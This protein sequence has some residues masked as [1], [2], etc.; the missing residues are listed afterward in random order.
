MAVQRNWYNFRDYDCFKNDEM[1]LFKNGDLSWIIPKEV[2]AMSS[3]VDSKFTRNEDKC[4][5][6]RIEN[7]LNNLKELQIG[8]VLRLNEPLY[9]KN[10][11]L[12]SG[13][14]HIDLFFEDG[15]TP[16]SQILKLFFEIVKTVKF[17]IAVHCKA[18]L[19][20]TGTLICIYMNSKYSIEMEIAVAW[21]KICRP[22]S[23]TQ[24]QYNFLIELGKTNYI[25]KFDQTFQLKPSN[26]GMTGNQQMDFKKEERRVSQKDIS[27]ARSKTVD[28]YEFKSQQKSPNNDP[29]I[30]CTS[31][32][33]IT[34]QQKFPS[35]IFPDLNRL[36]L[37]NSS[38]FQAFEKKQIAEEPKNQNTFAQLSEEK[39]IFH[40][41]LYNN[42]IFSTPVQK[43]NYSTQ[44]RIASPVF[45][46]SPQVYI[47]R[48]IEVASENQTTWK[49]PNS[50]IHYTGSPA[51]GQIQNMKQ[52]LNAKLSSENLENFRSVQNLR[53]ERKK[54]QSHFEF[55]IETA[56]N[57]LFFENKKSP[58]EKQQNFARSSIFVN[59]SRM[60]SSHMF[61]L[62]KENPDL[63]KNMD[64]RPKSPHQNSV[65]NNE[66]PSP[67]SSQKIHN[68]SHDLYQKTMPTSEM[69]D[70]FKSKSH[71]KFKVNIEPKMDFMIP[72]FTNQLSDNFKIKNQQSNQLSK[73]HVQTKNIISSNLFANIPETRYFIQPKNLQSL[74]KTE[75]SKAEF[76]NNGYRTEYSSKVKY[77]PEEKVRDKFFD[78]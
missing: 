9:D 8:T 22:G 48:T 68:V 23:V 61:D 52:L 40:P 12:N 33:S 67:K 24:L 36:N 60:H 50:N 35:Q 11:F 10:K 71:L 75:I 3:P 28:S 20:R 78:N 63:K 62:Y 73:A 21:C 58:N 77:N 45:L 34:F 46:H 59:E 47:P 37:N 30:F 32:K 5:T 16:S 17:P 41:K 13:F 70:N 15:S 2:L 51:F 53:E 27:F 4:G 18:G 26:F 14:E 64:K 1:G 65:F 44:P 54:P 39:T 55:D 57:S 49:L 69:G 29:P 76:R 43:M 38:G 72:V 66:R 19:G 56:K 31:T 74:N 7:S 6:I 42:P 25:G